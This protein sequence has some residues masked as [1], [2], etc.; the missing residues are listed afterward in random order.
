MAAD[1][2]QIVVVMAVVKRD[3]KVLLALRDEEGID[4]A[5]MK[6]ELPGG[7][8]EFGEDPEATVVRE[9]K[10]ETGYDVKVKSMIPITKTS[11][12]DYPDH[13]RHV[14]L[15]G[16]DCEHVSGEVSRKDGKIK[17]VKWFRPAEIDWSSTLKWTKEFIE[18]SEINK[19]NEEQ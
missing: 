5:H 3:G 7:K 16:F 1:K 10:E 13:K 4:G 2:K 19:A 12:W 6:W 14:L 17:D 8:L 15:L 9:I 11:Q 18:Q